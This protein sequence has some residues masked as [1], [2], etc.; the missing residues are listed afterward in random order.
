MAAFF[1]Q[2][3]SGGCQPVNVGNTNVLHK[4]TALPTVLLGV[5]WDFHEVSNS[6]QYTS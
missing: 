4:G 3:E 5:L 1:L 6:T 2:I